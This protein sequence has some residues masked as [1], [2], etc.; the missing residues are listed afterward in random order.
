MKLVPDTDSDNS[1]A[2][3]DAENSGAHAAPVDGAGHDADGAVRDVDGLGISAFVDGESFWTADVFTELRIFGKVFVPKAYGHWRVTLDSLRLDADDPR[4]SCL[5]SLEQS[6]SL[7]RSI[8]ALLE[9]LR[10]VNNHPCALLAGYALPD[11]AEVFIWKN[12]VAGAVPG[13]IVRLF[14][15]VN[16]RE[17]PCGWCVRCRTID[18][19]AEQHEGSWVYFIR[20]GAGAIKIGR[21][22]NVGSRLATMQTANAEELRIVGRMPGG[23][24]VESMLHTRFAGARMR[25]EWFQATPDLLALIREIGGAAS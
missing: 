25:G 1:N 5:T 21:S 3:V 11:R 24:A 7:G 6:E 20:A 19:F 14:G 15:D 16:D 23:A 2:A 4:L 12:A 10:L 17:G 13:A 9:R 18:A 8:G 22:V